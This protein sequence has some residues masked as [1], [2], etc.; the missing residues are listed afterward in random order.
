MN[1]LRPLCAVLLPVYLLASD[2]PATKPYQKAASR[3]ESFIAA[4][5]ADKGIPALSIALE[6]Q[7]PML[8]CICS[9]IKAHGR[10]SAMR[11]PDRTSNLRC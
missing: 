2:V 10:L 4:E 6:I 11:R 7:L 8:A 5:I 9:A 1:F 3:L